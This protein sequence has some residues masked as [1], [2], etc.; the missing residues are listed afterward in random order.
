MNSKWFYI[1]ILAYTYY[2][3]VFWF[4]LRKKYLKHDPTEFTTRKGAISDQWTTQDQ[5]SLLFFVQATS[6]K[7][8]NWANTLYWC[9]QKKL[10]LSKNGIARQYSIPLGKWNYNVNG[11]PI[12]FPQENNFKITT[13]LQRPGIK[14]GRKADV[15]NTTL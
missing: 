1:S 6:S 15:E 9:M 2:T 4:A 12:D 5:K 3:L 10:C 7:F 13:L 14:P 11:E 8:S